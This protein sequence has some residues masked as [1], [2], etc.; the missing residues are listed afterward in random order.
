M[1]GQYSNQFTIELKYFIP[2]GHIGWF[3]NPIPTL[4][5]FEDG[6]IS[7]ISLRIQMDILVKTSVVNNI[8]IGAS[9]NPN[10]FSTY[11]AL[12]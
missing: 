2:L 11:K 10:E 1:E 9:C 8:L 4:D 7:N 6:N 12:F 3:K 5:S